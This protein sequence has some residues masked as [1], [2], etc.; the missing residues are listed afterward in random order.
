MSTVS[1]PVGEPAISINPPLSSLVLGIGDDD[2][3]S[4]APAI[5]V[6]KAQFLAPDDRND[7]FHTHTHTHTHTHIHTYSMVSEPTAADD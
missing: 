7:F 3:G 5:A 1:Y 6:Y 2:G 4:D